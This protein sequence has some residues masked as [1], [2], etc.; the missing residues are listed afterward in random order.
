MTVIRNDN[1]YKAIFEYCKKCHTFAQVSILIK[2]VNLIFLI[3]R[4]L[5]SYIPATNHTTTRLTSGIIHNICMV[6]NLTYNLPTKYGYFLETGLNNAIPEFSLAE[7]S[8][9]SRVMSHILYSTN[10]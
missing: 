3:S 7:P 8:L 2:V 5:L 10:M 4:A 9:T 1:G 6:V